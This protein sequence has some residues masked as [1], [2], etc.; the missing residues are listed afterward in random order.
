MG[1]SGS[2]GESAAI[3]QEGD[4]EMGSSYVVH[5]GGERKLSTHAGVSAVLGADEYDTIRVHVVDP[6]APVA[7]EGEF[8]LGAGAGKRFADLYTMGRL[9]G[10]GNEGKVYECWLTATDGDS[11]AEHYAVKLVDE[12]D[13]AEDE[14][15]MLLREV[16]LLKELTH[17]H[18]ERMV[19][20][21]FEGELCYIVTEL[22]TGGELIDQIL[23]VDHYTEKHARQTLQLLLEAVA[24]MHSQGVVHRDLK[25]QNLMLQD[26]RDDWHIKVVDFGMAK[27]CKSAKTGVG[28]GR[29]TSI[30]GTPQ[31]MAPEIFQEQDYGEKVDIWAVGVIAYIL[32]SGWPPFID[33][34]DDSE[35]RL[36][37]LVIGQ[38]LKFD[39]PVWQHMSKSSRDFLQ[40]AMAKDPANR[41][42]AQ[43]LLE[44]EWIVGHDEL[45]WVES[46]FAHLTHSHAKLG[47]Y[48]RSHN[49]KRAEK[50]KAKA[51]K[52]EAAKKSKAQKEGD[53]IAE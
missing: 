36:A 43:K 44:H 10:V 13:M 27:R 14:I 29:L 34:E 37:E 31:Y 32:L 21:V 1:C 45:N 42:S 51:D 35:E 53:S 46:T 9:L 30:C 52:K 40:L 39:D 17:P 16:E 3:L 20:A 18:I 50:A 5:E 6:S 7:G 48:H 15:E 25:P 8:K 41:P 2:K 28:R 23:K 33:L 19:D 11:T 22:L 24:H 38:G 4:A 26:N 12:H 47:T 49:E